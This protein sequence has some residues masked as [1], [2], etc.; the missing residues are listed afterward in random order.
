MK[1]DGKAESNLNR[2]PDAETRGLCFQ[3]GRQL[4]EHNT[5]IFLDEE[6]KGKHG[7]MILRG[8]SGRV[9]TL[10]ERTRLYDV[11]TIQA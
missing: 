3:A 6:L 1:A 10:F 5:G 8:L 2:A 4:V 11:F 9:K 7:K